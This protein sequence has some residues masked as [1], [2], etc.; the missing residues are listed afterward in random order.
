MSNP[1]PR[2]KDLINQNSSDSARLEDRLIQSQNPY[3]NR[4][5]NESEDGKD[6]E[7]DEGYDYGKMD[8]EPEDDGEY[9][10]EDRGEE[11]SDVG[12]PAD[13]EERLRALLHA[14]QSLQGSLEGA[15]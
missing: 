14:K 12:D 8:G 2:D 6:E 15:Q 7:V 5:P 13:R 9:D 4:S 11:L 3:E 10:G 1:P